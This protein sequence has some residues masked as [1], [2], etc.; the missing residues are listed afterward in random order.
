[1][2]WPGF[3]VLL[4]AS[5]HPTVQAA[6]VVAYESDV[7]AY[8]EAV[9]GVRAGMGDTVPLLID[10]H[11]PGGA[12]ELARALGARDT[13]VVIAVGTR[14]LSEVQSRKPAARVFAAMVLHASGADNLAGRVDLDVSL[15]AQLAVL[16][17]LFPHRTRVGII[18]N[19]QRAQYSA[20]ASKRARARR[21][22]AWWWWS[23]TVPR[24]CSRRWPP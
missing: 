12:A 1:M 22:S 14:A 3:W 21:V 11:A 2:S 19:P 15:P 13:R 24:A 5:V 18:R 10:L 17:A 23:A 9:E 8:V 6:V 20:E 4:A 7:G 16:K